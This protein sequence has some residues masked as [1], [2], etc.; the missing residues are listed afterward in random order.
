[1][2]QTKVP[3]SGIREQDKW[4]YE[5]ISE[6]SVLGRQFAHA[7]VK[8]ATG[9]GDELLKKKKEYPPCKKIFW[10]EPRFNAALENT[11]S[12]YA[13]DAHALEETKHWKK[14][15]KKFVGGP[16]FAP[17]RNFNGPLAPEEFE[18]C[19]ERPTVVFERSVELHPFERAKRYTKPRGKCAA[20]PE[21]VRPHTTV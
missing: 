10:E 19:F 11:N 18:H 6:E 16:R 4:R 13:Y 17:P 2:I 8:V 21:K 15:G 7:I 9:N 1:M 14:A 5:E 3:L 12:N 20:N